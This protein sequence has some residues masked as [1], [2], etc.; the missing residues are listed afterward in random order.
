MKRMSSKEIS[1]EGNGSSPPRFASEALGGPSPHQ[2]EQDVR[3][4]LLSQPSLHFASLVVRRIA[5][6]V[7]LQGVLEA[8]EGSPDVSSIA[9]KVAGVNCVLN[10]LLI[11]PNRDLSVHDLPVKG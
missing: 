7:C 4:I 10:H 11:A 6:G 5:D 2:V 9:Q 3:R 1:R 8:D